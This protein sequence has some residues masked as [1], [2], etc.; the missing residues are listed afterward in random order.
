MV[1]CCVVVLGQGH[2]VGSGGLVRLFFEGGGAGEGEKGVGV[3][4]PRVTIVVI[5]C[6]VNEYADFVD[7][8]LVLL[9]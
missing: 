4:H 6:E 2:R 8:R 7:G 3:R 9:R 5:Y 1:A